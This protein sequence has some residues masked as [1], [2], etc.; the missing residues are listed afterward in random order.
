MVNI[1]TYEILKF[2]LTCILYVFIT[3]TLHSNIVIRKRLLE[4]EKKID[5]LLYNIENSI[6]KRALEFLVVQG[7]SEFR[8]TLEGLT[9]DTKNDL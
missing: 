2:I 6:N 9:H 4:K 1:I 3:F 8:K 7:Y 5:T